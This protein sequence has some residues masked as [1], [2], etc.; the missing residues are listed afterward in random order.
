MIISWKYEKRETINC[1]E[2]EEHDVFNNILSEIAVG[3]QNKSVTKGGTNKF[4]QRS[5]Q[6]DGYFSS[7]YF[8][9]LCSWFRHTEQSPLLH[10]IFQKPGMEVNDLP[11]EKKEEKKNGEFGLH[12]RKRQRARDGDD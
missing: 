8:T 5:Q 6:W 12:L 10:K 2:Q 7:N 11:L 4:S 1:K 3:F 9:Y